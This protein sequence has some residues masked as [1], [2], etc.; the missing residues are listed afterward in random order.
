M[1]LEKQEK[2]DVHFGAQQTAPQQFD[3]NNW[4]NPY[5]SLIFFTWYFFTKR[6]PSLFYLL[7]SLFRYYYSS[8]IQGSIYE[9]WMDKGKRVANS[10]RNYTYT[11]SFASSSQSGNIP[12]SQ[13][14]NSSHYIPWQVTLFKNAITRIFFKN[15]FF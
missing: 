4:I 12:F 1:E 5:R 10:S 13:I 9:N 6:T 15:E 2:M 8:S 7:V 14:Q 11:S 3:T